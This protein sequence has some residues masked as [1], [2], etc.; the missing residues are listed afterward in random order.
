MT[1]AMTSSR[2]TAVLAGLALLLWA[3][4]APAQRAAY[5]R[6]ADLDAEGPA[7]VLDL[8][9]AG[10]YART[11]AD[12][13]GVR[14]V[15][16]FAL[17][18]RLLVGRRVAYCAGLDGELGGSGEGLVYGATAYLA[19]VGARFG[20]AGTIALCGGAG[21]DGVAD[22]VPLAARFPLELSLAL[23][24]GPLRATPWARAVWTAGDAARSDGVSWTSAADEVEAG[25]LVRFGRQRR[26]WS[27][28][29]AGGGLAVGVVHRAFMGTS[30]TGVVI[31]L[32][33]T[34]AQ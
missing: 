22:A 6:A 15:G 24:V 31:G 28:V 26:Y 17:R 20:D 3:A 18:S 9:A 27:H 34:G 19:G 30:W 32:G 8:A 16:M 21:L 1:P 29:S 25:L 11:D 14:D 5:V 10:Q 2:P 4:P 33:L 13:A 12:L 23:D 7:H